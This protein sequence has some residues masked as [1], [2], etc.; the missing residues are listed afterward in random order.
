MSIFT[1]IETKTMER[2]IPRFLVPAGLWMMPIAAMAGN[3]LADFIN[4]IVQLINNVFIPFILALAFLVFI[5]GVFQ[6][7]IAGSDED[8]RS[9]GRD[10]VLYG[11]LGFFIILSAWGLIN[12]LVNQFGLSGDEGPAQDVNTGIDIG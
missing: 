10:K 2:L 12:L 6:F 7:F 11:L 8:A 9:A 3:N 5:W 1:R 4:Q